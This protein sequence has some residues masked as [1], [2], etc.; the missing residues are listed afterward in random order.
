[1]YSRREIIERDSDSVLVVILLMPLVMP[2]TKIRPDRRKCRLIL[3]GVHMLLNVLCF[4]NRR[5]HFEDMNDTIQI[6]TMLSN[7]QQR[8]RISWIVW[9]YWI[10]I[11][12]GTGRGAMI[13]VFRDRFIRFI[14]VPLIWRR[15]W[16]CGRWQRMRVYRLKWLRSVVWGCFELVVRRFDVTFGFEGWQQGGLGQAMRVSWAGVWVSWW[17]VKGAEKTWDHKKG[18]KC[19]VWAPPNVLRCPPGDIDRAWELLKIHIHDVVLL[20]LGGMDIESLKMTVF[21][22]RQL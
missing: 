8:I 10:T 5:I 11:R 4:V 16:Q 17:S 19:T 18:E 20:H 12:R 9:C 6:H 21:V 1:M 3:D 2:R 22:K 15:W 13:S 14:V 7:T